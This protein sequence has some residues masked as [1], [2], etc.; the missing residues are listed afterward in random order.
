ME[1]DQNLSVGGETNLIL[2][3]NIFDVNIE[4]NT[5]EE[6][7]CPPYLGYNLFVVASWY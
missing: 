5:S 4:D 1:V 3:T 7:L 6:N 2:S